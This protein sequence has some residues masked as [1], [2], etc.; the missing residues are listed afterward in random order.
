[1]EDKEELANYDA[2]VYRA[3]AQ[4]ADAMTAELRGLKIPFFV[5]QKSLIQEPSELGSI[6]VPS[7]DKGSE[8]SAKVAKDELASFQRRMLELLQD[9]CK[10]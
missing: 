1:M 10:E 2:K 9:L 4:M 3:S 5:I 7:Q 8:G 6:G